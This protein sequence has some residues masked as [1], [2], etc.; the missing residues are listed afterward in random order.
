[1][2]NF[3]TNCLAGSPEFFACST[4]LISLKNSVLFLNFSLVEFTG[5]SQH[6]I[7]LCA[8]IYRIDKNLQGRRNRKEQ[9]GGGNPPPQILAYQL[10][11][12]QSG[13]QIIP[14]TLILTPRIF[15]PSYG[16]E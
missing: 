12:L 9:G 3:L 14:T 6:R 5:S 11:L 8:N 16:P 15:R 13:G 1:M 7:V 10:T 2:P 4:A